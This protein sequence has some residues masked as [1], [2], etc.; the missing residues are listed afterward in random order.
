MSRPKPVIRK[1][2]ELQNGQL[3]DFFALLSERSKSATRD[4]KPFFLCKF[5]DARRTASYLVWA[6]NERYP[7]CE[8][9]WQPGMFFKIRATFENHRQYGP[10]LEVHNLR[11]VNEQDRADGFREADLLDRS[12]IDP[13]DMFGE[14]RNLAETSIG[15]EPLRKLA[16]LLLDA[17]AEKLK[18]LPGST[19]HYYPF[20]GGW[21]EHTLS[22]TGKCLW[23]AERYQE[24]D[25]D[26]TPPLNRDLVVAGAVLHE[27][28]RAIE[29]EPGKTPGEPAEKTVAG[30]LFGHITLGRDMVHDAAQQVSDLNPELLRL[31]E[32]AI[33]THLAQPEWGSPRLPL[34]PE[35]LILHFANDLDARMEMFMR[36][37][38]KDVSPGPFTERD[39]TLGKKLLKG[40]EV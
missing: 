22:V 15:D 20:P 21:L 31:L 33:L 34:I 9:E 14:L 26:L 16:L 40:R 8:A 4:G 32:H 23:L 35:A 13:A 3:A 37:L 30:E 18:A 28:G 17:H 25:P 27:I 1:L 39:P 11:L 5:R 24:Q 7:E 10:R 19:R 12:R 29:L 36:C 6:D 2:S 38:R